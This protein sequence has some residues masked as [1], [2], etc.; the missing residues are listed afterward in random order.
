M[1]VFLAVR[2]FASCAANGRKFSV[3]FVCIVFLR[4]LQESNKECFYWLAIFMVLVPYK[5]DL[6]TFRLSCIWQFQKLTF[7]SRMKT[8]CNELF[9]HICHYKTIC[10][11]SVTYYVI[12]VL[13]CCFLFWSGR[14][15]R[16]H[17]HL[18][19]RF[20]FN[21]NKLTGH[22][23][24]RFSR[25]TSCVYVMKFIFWRAEVVCVFANV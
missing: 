19:Q 12:V 17:D 25:L 7:C 11:L 18:S 20:F 23:N 3:Y 22:F 21:F 8:V 15:L 6:L 2:S 14:L 9:L 1:G 5:P 4:R 10:R 24:S 13:A 16:R